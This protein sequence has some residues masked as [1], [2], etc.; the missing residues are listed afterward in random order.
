MGS[1]RLWYIIGQKVK[2]LK[3]MLSNLCLTMLIYNFSFPESNRRSPS[4]R[5]FLQK[6]QNSPSSY[7]RFVDVYCFFYIL[8]K[9]NQF[10][11]IRFVHGKWNY[12]SGSLF[13]HKTFR[14]LYTSQSPVT[15]GS[16][17][18]YNGH[19]LFEIINKINTIYIK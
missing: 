5:R 13:S 8:I 18:R 19:G 4:L 1:K 12:I 2:N 17:K 10:C 15:M 7:L 16:V 3:K 14:S 9:Y 6:C 11:R